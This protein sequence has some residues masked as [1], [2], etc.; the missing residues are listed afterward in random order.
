MAVYCVN[1]FSIMMFLSHDSY[2]AVCPR[3]HSSPQCRVAQD[4]TSFLTS[5]RCVVVRTQKAGLGVRLRLLWCLCCFH[6]KMLERQKCPRGSDDTDLLSDARFDSFS[7]D[8][9]RV[10]KIFLPKG[11]VRGLT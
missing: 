4:Q 6:L 5:Y 10:Q 2:S 8:L 9:F 11:M 3:S 7:A 1:H